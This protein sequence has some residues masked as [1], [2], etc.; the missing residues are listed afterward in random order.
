M[1]A[2]AEGYLK[3]AYVRPGDRVKEGQLL[4]ELADE[5]LKLEERK[6][7][8]EVSQMENAYGTALVKQDRA[9]VAI[10]GAKLEE[11]RAQLALVQSRLQRTKLV[12]PFDA[13]VIT[14][15]PGIGGTAQEG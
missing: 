8:S 7:Q 2:P 3:Q 10:V 12:A 6:A 4:A 15:E 9:E 5:D 1:V 13:L 14:G 11:G